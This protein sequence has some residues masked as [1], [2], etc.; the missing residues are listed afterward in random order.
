MERNNCKLSVNINKVATLRNARGGTMPDLVKFAIDCERFGA[1]GITVHPRPDERHIRI[2]DVFDL[3][4]VVKT[5]FNIEGYPSESFLKLVEEIKPDQV[6][7][8]PDPPDV[9]TSNAGWDT[10]RNFQLLKDISSRLQSGGMRVS[11]FID[12]DTKMIEKAADIGVDRIELYTEAYA[13]SFENDPQMA[14]Q[15]YTIAAKTAM[16][17]GLGLNAG[18]DLNLKNLKYF[19]E[20]VEGLMEVSIGHALISDALYYGIENTIQMYRRCL[21]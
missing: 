7:L 1:E 13:S 5:E 8:V 2:Q 4:K 19:N 18:H 10:V 3:K 6:T 16:S 9:L 21:K 20:N 17:A 15:N 14:I 12:P 11:V